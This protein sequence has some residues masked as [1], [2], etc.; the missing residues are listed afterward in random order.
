VVS[1]STLP[2]VSD[3]AL[4]P[5]IEA[6]LE[7][8]PATLLGHSGR[9][10]Y[11]GRGAF[12]APNDAY[13]LGLNPGGDPDRQVAETVSADLQR[14][15]DGPGW[16]S[17]YADESWHGAAPGTWGMAPRVLHLLNSLG[18]DPRSVPASNV[19]FVRSSTEATLGSNKSALL[20]AC[21]PVHRA[22]IEALNAHVI[23]CLGGTAGRWCRQQLDAS[24]LVDSFRETNSRGWCSETHEADGG[25]KVL[26]LTHPGRANWCNP[27]SDPSDLVMRALAQAARTDVM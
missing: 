20:E 26:T 25:R 12:S 4:R 22:V 13:I 23:L 24:R 27:D 16:W 10:F 1:A 8:I 17:A 9:V 14:F 19:M 5:E 3:P 21:W 11:S 15:R 7:G 6:A 2:L 18:L